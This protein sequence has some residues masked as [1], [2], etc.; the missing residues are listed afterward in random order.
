M[1]R[2]KFGI[3]SLGHFCKTKTLMKLVA[4]NNLND[5]LVNQSRRGLKARQILPSAATSETVFMTKEKL[6]PFVKVGRVTLLHV[7]TH[8]QY[9]I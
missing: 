1:L 8:F 9:F 3:S 2:W 4:K 6:Q 7:P 5:I